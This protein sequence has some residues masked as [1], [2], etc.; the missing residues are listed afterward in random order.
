MAVSDLNVRIAIQLQD[1]EKSLKSME[2]SLRR[3]GQNMSRLGSEM[4][5][6][7][8]APLAI[9]GA[10]AITAAGDMEALRL[11]IQ[12][13][14]QDAGYSIEQAN[15]E[16]EALRKAALAPGLDFEQAVKGSIRLQNIGFT[17]EKSRDI[18]VQLANA[19]AMT[20]GSAKELDSV[21]RQFTQMLA[22]GRV[23]QE[24]LTIIQENMPK[25]SNAM[26]K[27]FGTKSAEKLRDMGISAEQFIDGVTKQLST[28][29]RVSGGIK[30]AI[31]NAG[32]SLTQFFARIGEDIARIFG[33]TALG[34]KFSS[35]LDTMATYWE[36][37]SDSTKSTVLQFVLFAAAIGPIIKLFGVLKLAQAQ[38][39]GGLAGMV[40][41]FK[42][43]ISWVTT[44]ATKFTALSTAMKFMYGGIAVVA[45]TALVAVLANLDN[46]VGAL[47]PKFKHLSEI[48]QAATKAATDEKAAIAPL[49]AVLNDNTASLDQ[50]GAAIKRL[51]EIS[52]EYFKNLRIEKG[53]VMGLTESYEGYINS[54]IRASK[55]KSSEKKL[56]DFAKRKEALDQERDFIDAAKKANTQQYQTAE[57]YIRRTEEL[58]KMSSVLEKNT[59]QLDEETKAVF[60]VFKANSD[61]FEVRTSNTAA[62][63]ASAS[64][65]GNAADK[66][67]SLASTYREVLAE[68]SNI[69]KK[70]IA[71]N[72]QQSPDAF[73]AFADG[74]DKGVDKL[75]E[76]GA[77]IDGPEI[78]KL[79]SLA[80]GMM[81]DL[82]ESPTIPTLPT[83]LSVQSQEDPTQA[84]IDGFKEFE[85]QAQD[86]S[87]AVDGLGTSF[88]N[89]LA[90]MG[91]SEEGM[92]AFGEGM[93]SMAAVSQEAFEG[94]ANSLMGVEGA[95]TNTGRAALIA[96][97]QMVKAALA[98][99]LAKAIQDS[100]AK[101]GHPLAGLIVSGIV[102]GGVT[103]LFGRL[104]Q[105][106]GKAPK[107]AKGAIV[108]GPTM[109]M[110]GDNPG[111]N[112]DPE[113]IAPLSRLKSM[114]GNSSGAVEVY[115]TIRGEDLLLLTDKAMARRKRIR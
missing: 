60:E 13:T 11:A 59:K 111:A 20:G 23:M 42:N 8:T 105:E 6:A 114:I 10:K 1:W 44:S 78:Q 107:F 12:S 113:V 18:I 65:T 87:F 66:T 73:E 43:L 72:A 38:V 96:A 39:I 17:A 103:A 80:S 2:R 77:K 49:I 34:D 67:K 21:T 83:P 91:M 24:D 81:G 36:T 70:Y 47:N 101:S 9:M 15:A 108:H 26:E 102:V 55:A 63:N 94:V 85:I 46:M 48:Q 45:V 86:T 95:Y 27:A 5:L 90:N 50:K 115:G 4:S 7:I 37:L 89:M 75:I 35:M 51:Q 30:N 106:V 41:G 76:A 92:T 97:M 71:L 54:I 74:I 68:L 22:K 57:G 93:A 56:E 110:V 84:A 98:A 112:V 14:M 104:Q 61:L 69:E 40:G 29:P 99:T 28:L 100:M 31:V 33:L 109:A 82:P 53:E 58:E 32:T 52:P 88:V 79:R 64:A 3:T 19:I 25:I 16:L 62:T